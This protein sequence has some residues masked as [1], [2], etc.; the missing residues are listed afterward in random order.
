MVA[1]ETMK[2]I[3]TLICGVV[4]GGISASAFL[5]FET[6]SAEVWESH[7][8]LHTDSGITFPAGTKFVVAEYAPEGFVAL[9]LTVNVEGQELSSFHKKVVNKAKNLRIPIWAQISN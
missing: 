5:Y 8:K 6:G 4:I 2:S 9:T 3:I 1:K 7:T